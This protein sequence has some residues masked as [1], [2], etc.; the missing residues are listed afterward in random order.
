M[1]DWKQR[2]VIVCL[3]AEQHKERS[4]KWIFRAHNVWKKRKIYGEYHSL[5]L[6]SPEHEAKFW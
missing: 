5:Y 1:S 3:S 6:E 2:T 4:Y